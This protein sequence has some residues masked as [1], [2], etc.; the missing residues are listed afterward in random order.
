[1]PFFFSL[2]VF[3]GRA[4]VLVK[5]KGKENSFAQGLSGGKRC[6]RTP[7]GCLARKNAT[8]PEVVKVNND[9]FFELN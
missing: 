1:M 4:N 7:C 5:L 2:D 9:Q 6:R 8:I 3:Q